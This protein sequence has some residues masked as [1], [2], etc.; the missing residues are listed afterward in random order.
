MSQGRLT[1]LMICSVVKEADRTRD[2]VECFPYFLNALSAF[3]VLYNATDHRRGLVKELE[4]DNFL[5]HSASP[6][7]LL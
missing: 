4:F 5:T 3:Q 7:L 6:A 2:A 1:E